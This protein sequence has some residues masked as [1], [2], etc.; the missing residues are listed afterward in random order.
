METAFFYG[1]GDTLDI[2]SLS[3]VILAEGSKN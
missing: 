1:Q 2:N 3:E